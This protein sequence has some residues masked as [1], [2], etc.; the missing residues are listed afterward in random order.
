MAQIRLGRFEAE[1]RDLP[2]VCMCCGAPATVV[3][4]KSFKWTPRTPPLRGALNL[5]GLWPYF[6]VASAQTKRMRVRIPLCEKHRNHWV[7]RAW[8]L[9]G[10][11][12]VLGGLVVLYVA[13]LIAVSQLGLNP[14]P[15]LGSY[16]CPGLLSAG[17]IYVV[18]MLVVQTE[19]I[20][21]T[22]IT[23]RSITLIN[24]S[25]RFVQAVDDFDQP[26]GEALEAT[27][28]D[29]ACAPL[30]PNHPGRNRPPIRQPRPYPISETCPECGQTTFK[31]VKPETF[32]AFTDDR[33]CLGC[34]TRYTPPTPTWAAIVFLIVGTGIVLVALLVIAVEGRDG[35]CMAG[36]FVFTSLAVGIACVIHGI[37]TVK[38][39][40]ER[41]A[42]A[43]G[44]ESD[45][46]YDPGH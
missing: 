13:I 39:R 34:G 14:S 12:A 40:G 10:G 30:A 4:S 26:A 5:V 23:D 45:R 15:A 44:R 21:P 2:A 24:V 38:N 42:L 25:K 19:A 31:P 3:K 7:W 20:R 22:E 36:M 35:G 46:F 17:V 41:T 6:S 11:R 9:H 37:R 16:L 28:T 33:L 27:G 43:P 18:A 1:D 29:P 32:V 8:L